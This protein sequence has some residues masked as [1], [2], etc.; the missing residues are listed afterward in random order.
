MGH[1]CVSTEA[2]KDTKSLGLQTTSQICDAGEGKEEKIMEETLKRGEGMG[3][4]QEAHPPQG[5]Q[6]E[7]KAD[8]AEP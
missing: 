8:Q 4:A 5:A 7:G 1:I 6:D 3:C 2:V